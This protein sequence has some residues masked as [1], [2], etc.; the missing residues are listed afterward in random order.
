MA[1]DTVQHLDAKQTL[2]KVTKLETSPQ[3]QAT[4]T[5]QHQLS[6]GRDKFMKR[7]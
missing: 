4:T 6:P 7:L 2:Q 3:K 1:F 5:I